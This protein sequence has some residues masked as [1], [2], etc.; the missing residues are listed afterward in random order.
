MAD[1]GAE[2]PAAA[3]LRQRAAAPQAGEVGALVEL[4]PPG[5][6]GVV[7]RPRDHR[8]DRLR[9]A[10]SAPSAPPSRPTGAWSGTEDLV[11]HREHRVD[12][13]GSS[14]TAC[15][16]RRGWHRQVR[17]AIS[18]TRSVSTGSGV[19]PAADSRSGG[20]RG[21]RA[22]RASTRR[23]RW[24]GRPRAAITSSASASVGRSRRRWTTTRR[25]RPSGSPVLGL[26]RMPGPA[27]GWRRICSSKAVSTARRSTAASEHAT[28]FGQAS[29]QTRM[30]RCGA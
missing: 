8:L 12:A 17:S 24:R 3:P 22:S 14:T 9:L 18:A 26:D 5:G 6:D 10:A 13:G 28:A 30:P 25:C 20:P 11:V 27:A 19:N 29:C 23:S 7:A 15:A 2:D 16:R 4:D 21:R 1:Q